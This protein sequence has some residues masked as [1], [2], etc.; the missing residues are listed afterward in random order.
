[1]IIV[2]DTHRIKVS[3]RGPNN[4][5]VN[6]GTMTLDVTLPDG[7]VQSVPAIAGDNTGDVY[8]DFVC[9]LPGRHR[10]VLRT[11]N[12]VTAYRDVFDVATYTDTAIVSLAEAK[13]QLNIRGSSDDAEIRGYI[14]ATTP[15][16]EGYVGPTV[17]REYTDSFVCE[18]VLLR[19][20][21]TIEIVEIK[22]SDGS[23]LDLSDVSFDSFGQVFVSGVPLSGTYSV[24]YTAGFAEIPANRTRAALIII[25][26]MWETQRPADPRRPAMAMSDE[27]NPQDAVGR[28]FSIPRRAIEL[29]EPDM[30]GGIA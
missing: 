10:F 21:P 22:H 4:E 16:I 23:L 30:L 24:S 27:F 28:Y 2:D 19:A 13:A 8:G 20:K 17:I 12:P 26:H 14:A 9:T 25:Q 15:I 29:L 5:L 11:T 18:S 6:P 3:V 7:N 1:M